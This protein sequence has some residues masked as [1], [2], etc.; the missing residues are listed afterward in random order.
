MIRIGEYQKHFGTAPS[1]VA[2]SP[3]RVNLIGEHID[4]LDGFVMPIAID[5]HL[6]IEAAP[7]EDGS[8]EIV[9]VHVGFGGP[10]KFG[11]DE[12]HRREA[13]EDR[14]MN[15]LLG[16]I[17]GYREAGFEVPGFRAVI[18][19]DLPAGA[20]LSASAALETATALVIE[21]LGDTKIGIVERALL[22]QRAEHEYAGVPCGIMDQLAV[23]AGKAGQ[24]LLL[25]CRDYSLRHFPMPEE[26]A[27]LV[28]DTGVKHA[29]ADGE[30]RKRR[31]NCESAMDL[32]GVD[33]LR[34]V[35]LEAVEAG[36]GLLG[37]TLFRRARHA[38]TEMERVTCF[39]AALEAGDLKT[40]GRILREGH[41]SLRD[42]YEVS[43]P[44]LDSLVEA[45]YAFGSERGH[46]GTRMTGGGFG[47]STISLVRTE[48]AAALQA[49]LVDFFAERFGATPNAFITSAVDGA[50]VHVVE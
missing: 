26:L 49:H 7:T 28:T 44:E 24:A 45:G 38:V 43:C 47:G 27:V 37:E 29:L 33:S 21:A 11:K 9:P 13:K 8:F 2:V 5:R 4:Y 40:L 41:E 39:A 14:W 20:G 12:I 36:R 1:A 31:E 48:A 35:S 18:H 10:A 16:V 34:D 23:G 42:D 17:S 15:Y 46:I 30:Y 19:A 6:M 50:S 22:C 32:L 3:G 25:D